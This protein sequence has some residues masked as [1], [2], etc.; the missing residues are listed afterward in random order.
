MKNGASGYL[1][2]SRRRGRASASRCL[3]RRGPA[4]RGHDAR[5]GRLVG[6]AAASSTAKRQPIKGPAETRPRGWTSRA[7]VSDAFATAARAY[8]ILT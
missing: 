7:R 5:G 1:G 6:G 2:R 8:A 4:T 3:A